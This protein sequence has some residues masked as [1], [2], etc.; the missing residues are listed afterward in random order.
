VIFS[1]S[2]HL[3]SVRVGSECAQPAGESVQLRCLELLLKAPVC[4]L[5]RL[6]Y[7]VFA[8]ASA[9]RRLCCSAGRGQTIRHGAGRGL[10]KQKLCPCIELLL[11]LK[12]RRLPKYLCALRIVFLRP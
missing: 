4:M 6:R 1:I 9:M 2:S 10:R 3:V 11:C 5:K 8:K 12:I 7:R